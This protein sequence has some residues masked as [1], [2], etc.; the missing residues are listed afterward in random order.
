MLFQYSHILT[1]MEI[2]LASELLEADCIKDSQF[3]F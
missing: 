3:N 1:Y 2:L